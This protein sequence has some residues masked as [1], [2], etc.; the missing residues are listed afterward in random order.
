MND[1]MPAHGRIPS[2]P[3]AVSLRRHTS[4][5]AYDVSSGPADGGHP[6]VTGSRAGA[7]RR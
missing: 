7:T 1:G 3:G 5:D 6:G 2:T 4:V